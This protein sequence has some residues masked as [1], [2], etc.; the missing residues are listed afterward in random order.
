MLAAVLLVVEPVVPVAV[1]AREGFVVPAPSEAV[2]ERRVLVD[3]V[4]VLAVDVPFDPVADP[5]VRDDPEEED[6]P[7]RDDLDEDRELEDPVPDEGREPGLLDPEDRDEEL[8]REVEE[9]EFDREEE[10]RDPV[11][12]LDDRE[13][14]ELV[15]RRPELVDRLVEEP[16]EDVSEPESPFRT[17]DH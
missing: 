11:E 9:L 5:P 1:C 13:R 16:V 7:E 14:L 12:E 17:G 10:L 8:D 6:P 3:D 2:S 4:E 15:D